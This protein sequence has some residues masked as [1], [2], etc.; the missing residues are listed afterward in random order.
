[1]AALNEIFPR[2]IPSSFPNEFIDVFSVPK[3][4]LQRGFE[5][6]SETEINECLYNERVTDN[7]G[8]D[9]EYNIFLSK[10][11]EKKFRLSVRNIIYNNSLPNEVDGFSFTSN[12]K[13]ELR[14]TKTVELLLAYLCIKELKALSA[15]FGVKIK[16]TP[17]GADFDCIANFQNTLFHFEVKSDNINNLEKED[18]Q[19]FLNRH[20]FLSPSASVLFLDYNGGFDKLDNILKNLST[21]KLVIG[22]LIELRKYLMTQKNFI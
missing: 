7:L 10:F 5:D 19:N 16:N 11:N 1:M 20:N 4:L 6:I 13:T 14:Y 8:N 22:M 21:S 17:D 15:S 12:E 9:F 18:F 2:N 3:T